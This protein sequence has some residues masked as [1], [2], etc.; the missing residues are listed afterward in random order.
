MPVPVTRRAYAEIDDKDRWI[1]VRFPYNPTVK[2]EVHDIGGSK[3]IGVEDGGPAWRVPKDV[4]TCEE[5]RRIF[6]PKKI[7]NDIH[8]GGLFIGDKLRAWAKVEFQKHRNLRSLAQASDAELHHIAPDSRIARAIRGEPIPELKLPPLPSGKPHPLMIERPARPYQRADIQ[9]MALTDAMNANQPG[10]GKTLECVG[11]WVESQLWDAG[12]H[13]VVAP[14]R[15]LEN[16][17]LDEVTMWLP[18][19]EVWT[20]ED[21]RERTE[22]VEGFLDA[23][24]SDAKYNGVVCVNFDWV[25]L[26][27]TFDVK[28]PT[29]KYERFSDREIEVLVRKLRLHANTPFKF[30]T[31]SEWME[32]LVKYDRSP[33]FLARRDN[34][35]NVYAFKS[36]L[37]QRLFAIEYATLT[38]DEFHKA[39]LNNRNS[40]FSLGVT[41]IKAK[42]RAAMSGTPMGGKP[43]KLWPV[44]N[45]LAPEEY[46]SEWQWIQNWL[47]VSD[48]GHGKKVGDLLVDKEDQFYEAHAGRLV[49]RLKLEALPGLPVRTEDVVWCKM[50]PGQKRQYLEFEEKLE[51]KIDEERLAATNILTEYA[52]LKQF[53][54]AKQRMAEGVP[55]PTSDSGKLEQ[56]LQ[57][58]DENGIR[59]DDPEP[60]ARAIVGSESARMVEMVTQFL[61]AKG[62]EA[63]SL[64]GA[65]RD[66]KPLLRRFKGYEPRTPYVIVMTMQTGG[67]SLNLEEAGSA[68]ALDETWNPDDIEQ[69]F[70]RGDRGSRTEPLRCYIYRTRDTIQEYIAEVNEGKSVTNTNVLDLRRQ[71]LILEAERGNYRHS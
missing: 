31:R 52:R 6:G 56:L 21:T 28:R 5:L 68:H 37:Q 30:T 48:D 47:T 29:K 23:A 20:A 14:V 9:M 66:A 67:V 70:D 12:P 13:I 50:T 58:L 32:L 27:K 43:R 11:S 46:K 39:G 17:W 45:Y 40:L 49:R 1:E 55:F 26:V 42:K 18:D 35:G 54:N 71:V 10:T 61:R 19:S 64:T 15:S 44:F 16:V 34:K 8:V 59:K 7:R 53:A 25:R 57:R 63:E 62:I 60:G 51:I 69:F 22:Q 3:F 4:P 65:T 41:R 36:E 33:P 24:E 38:I 2:K